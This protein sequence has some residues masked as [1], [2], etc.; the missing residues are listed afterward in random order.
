MK[1]FWIELKRV[2]LS[3]EKK[4]IMLAHPVVTKFKRI[5]MCYHEKQNNK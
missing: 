1:I 2:S 4:E 5:T 3:F